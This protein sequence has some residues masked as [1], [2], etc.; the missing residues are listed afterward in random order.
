[1]MR[2]GRTRRAFLKRAAAGIGGAFAMGGTGLGGPGPLG[3]NER[4]GVGHVGI[5]W[6]GGAHLGHFAHHERFPTLAVCDVDERHLERAAAR[7]GAWCGKHR[8]YRELLDRP[9]I[10]AVVIA[11]PD[12]W[13]GL[14]SIHACEAG[15][16]VYCEKPLSLTIREGRAM[17]DA[18]R[19][20]GRV[21]QTGSQQRSSPEFLKACE[22]VRN[23]RI[24]RI[25]QVRVG[26]WGSSR[27]CDLPPEPTP[28]WMDWDMWIG[29]A[30]WRPYNKGIH[31][32]NWRA[33]RDYSGG[34]MTD[35]G[36][37][38]LDIAQW[39]LGMDHTGPIEIQ[40]PA[41]GKEHVTLKYANGIPVLCGN[42]GANGILFE[43]TEGTIEVNRGHFRADPAEIGREPLGPG[44][45]R[46]YHSPGHQAD[47]ENCVL[48][49]KRPICDVE[50]GHRSVTV[51][52]LSNIAIW[53]GRGFRWDPE[54]EVI[55]GDEELNRWLHR[56]MRAPWHL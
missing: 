49:R 56:P 36:A 13:H 4:I 55:T 5:N 17:V 14:T 28:E 33:Y 42:V 37:H 20:Y 43:G 3:A 11:V 19:R 1:M 40:P 30:P 16:D 35:W 2:R 22:L 39:G 27:E 51:C 26:V 24:G 38:H 15:K 25:K 44:D 21:F 41:E 34:T 46:L 31:P 10:E 54:K 18:A 29:P 53:T 12:H 6:M 48:S 7:V 23:G 50:I 9:E 8:D 52:H 32:V 47:W 45:T